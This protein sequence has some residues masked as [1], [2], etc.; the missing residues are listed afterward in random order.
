MCNQHMAIVQF[1]PEHGVG[2]G[3]NNRAFQ[4]DLLFFRHAIMCPYAV[5]RQKEGAILPE[6]AQGCK[7]KGR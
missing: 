7:A 2:Q 3:I 5:V 4:F 1:Y 6:M